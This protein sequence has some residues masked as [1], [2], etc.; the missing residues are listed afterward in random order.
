MRFWRR[1]RQLPT[2][3]LLPSLDRLSELIEGVVARLDQVALDP[4]PA[5]PAPEP[6][7]APPPV[8]AGHVLFVPAP[9]GYRLVQ[10]DGP[11]PDRGAALALE[12][13]AFRVL[14]LGPSPLPGDRRRCVF[15]VATE[16]PSDEARTPDE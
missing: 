5:S 2:S 1:R 11:P 15:V 6:D 14:R 8:Q 16:E 7:A 13:G 10:R 12:E 9:D 3:I 4:E